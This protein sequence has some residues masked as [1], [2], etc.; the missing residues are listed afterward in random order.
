MLV[1]VPLDVGRVDGVVVGHLELVQLGSE[2]LQ[3]VAHALAEH[4]GHEVE[5][6]RSWV[7]ET[8]SGGL[9]PEHGLA[10]HEQDVVLREE[11]LAGL[12]LG[13]AEELDEG[14][15]VVVG[16]LPALGGEH[17]RIGHRRPGAQGDV[18]IAHVG[19]SFQ[20]LPRS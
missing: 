15:V 4:A 1:Q 12:A 13:A 20:R 9:E 5:H 17:L 8:A 19:R 11:Q 10:L 18:R 14:R 7:D 6:R 16:D 2:V 3:P